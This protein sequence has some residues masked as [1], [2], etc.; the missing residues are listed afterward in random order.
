MGQA[1]SIR[2][3][4]SLSLSHTQEGSHFLFRFILHSWFLAGVEEPNEMNLSNCFVSSSDSTLFIKLCNC[5]SCD[6]MWWDEMRYTRTKLDGIGKKMG[7]AIK[8]VEKKEK[9]KK[10]RER[11]KF[12]MRLR[13]RQKRERGQCQLC[14]HYNWYQAKSVTSIF[15]AMLVS[16]ISWKVEGKCRLCWYFDRSCESRSEDT[17][18]YKTEI[19]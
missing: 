3:W 6:L 4:S 18:Q 19:E 9:R 12:G 14:E 10:G 7:L 15:E 2:L 5:L 16:L 1:G 11:T 8:D 13:R 17:W